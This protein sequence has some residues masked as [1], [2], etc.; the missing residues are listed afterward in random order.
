M[1][2]FHSPEREPRRDSVVEFQRAI[3]LKPD[4][5]RL[6]LKLGEAFTKLGNKQAALEQ[7]EKLQKLD[8]DAAKELLALIPANRDNVGND[9]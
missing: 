6:Y 7:Y 5:P 3:E 9:G 2:D 4:L 8:A 1:L